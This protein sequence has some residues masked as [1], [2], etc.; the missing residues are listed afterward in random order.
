MQTT[1]ANESDYIMGYILRGRI[2]ASFCIDCSDAIRTNH[3]I[4]WKMCLAHKN[5]HVSHQTIRENWISSSR[6]KKKKKSR[7]Q[8]QQNQPGQEHRANKM[9]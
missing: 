9:K 7:C 3:G 2:F 6:T 8:W 5:E 1:A 4:I